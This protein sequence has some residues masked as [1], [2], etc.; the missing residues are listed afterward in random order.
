MWIF[1]AVPLVG[2]GFLF[3]VLGGF[4]AID[5]NARRYVGIALSSLGAI[6][7]VAGF[8]LPIVGVVVFHWR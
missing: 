8:F 3:T 5:Q 1:L 6:M 7:G 2:F 4:Y